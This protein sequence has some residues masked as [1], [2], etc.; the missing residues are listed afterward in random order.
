MDL[1]IF[2]HC[3]G[4]EE[5]SYLLDA[6]IYQLANP[7]LSDHIKWPGPALHSQTLLTLFVMLPSSGKAYI[8]V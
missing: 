5:P 8:V 6:S 7:I 1:F 3:P 2:L 4:R